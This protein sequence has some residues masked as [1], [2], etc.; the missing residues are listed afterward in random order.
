MQDSVIEAGCELKHVIL[1]KVVTIR[2]GGRL[3]GE[4]KHP[5]IIGKGEVV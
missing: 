4:L 1:D 2:D 3:I 5:M